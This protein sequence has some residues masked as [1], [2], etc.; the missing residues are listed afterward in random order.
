MSIGKRTYQQRQRAQSAEAT[1]QRIIDAARLCLTTAPLSAVS[2]ER[3]AQEAGVARRT[4]YL[5]FGSRVGLFQALEQDVL[6]RGGFVGIQDAFNK[7]TNARTI[8]EEMVPAGV[9]L[10][11][12]EQAILRALYLHSI[13]DPEAAMLTKHID[14]G[15]IGGMRYLAQ[16][17]VEQGY[18]RPDL[19]TTEVGDILSL[20]TDF[21]TFDALRTRLGLSPEE[22]TQRLRLLSLCILR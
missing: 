21:A 3:I 5:V 4:I 6:K 9:R 2:L 10:L 20:L 17:L 16:L 19:T 13:V 15:R 14:E 8:L 1:R 18:A 12:R 11:E 22:V 7:N